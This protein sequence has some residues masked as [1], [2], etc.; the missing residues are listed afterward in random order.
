MR[1]TCS[2]PARTS[3]QN[4][5]EAWPKKEVNHRFGR[6]LT[7]LYTTFCLLFLSA[8]ASNTQPPPVVEQSSEA[9]I[10]RSQ[11]T[12]AETTTAKQPNAATRALLA[13]ADAASNNADHEAA[14][15]YLE[16][17]IRL[18][19]RSTELWTKLAR[20]H[21]AD[22]NLDAARQHARKAIALA[23]GNYAAERGAWLTFADIQEASGMQNEARDI[24]RRFSRARG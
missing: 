5:A 17:A 2:I 8:C 1:F 14:V 9:P 11:P 18:E 13:Q 12:N 21:L 4:R 19:P 3:R 22:G 15:L 24:R 20:A 23:Q 6:A 7:V 10:E 16:R